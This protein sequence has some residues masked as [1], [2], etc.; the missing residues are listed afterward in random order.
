MYNNKYW[1]SKS[2][3]NIVIT[4]TYYTYTHLVACQPCL[5]GSVDT[6]YY[7]RTLD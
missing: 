4:Y 7:D 5:V 2:V 3:I 1:L 6:F